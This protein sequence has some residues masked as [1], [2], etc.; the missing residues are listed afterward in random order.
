MNFHMVVTTISI[1]FS[2][3]ISHAQAINEIMASNDSSLFDFENDSPDW[4]ELYNDKSAAI[5]LTGYTLTDDP[6]K[7]YKWKFP[8][9]V[10]QPNEFLII[11]CSD[12]D[13]AAF[14]M[15]TGFKLDADG[16]F[17][18]LYNAAGVCVDSL[19]FPALKTDHSFG[20]LPDGDGE[21]LYMERPT[22]GNPNTSDESSLAAT[23]PT[24][25]H[26]SG[27]YDHAIHVELHSDLNGAE[28]H[29]TLDGAEPTKN[30]AVYF[31]AIAVDKTTVLRA[32][33][34]HQNMN[35]GP[36][37][38]RIFFI[39]EDATLFDMPIIALA[40]DP[41]NLWDQKTGIYAN[42]TQ[43]GDEWERPTN[44][45][46][47]EKGGAQ[48]FNVGAGVRIHGGASRKRADKKSFR[49]YFRSKYGPGILE[50]PIIP[51]TENDKFDRLIL[52]AGYNDSWA[53]W[54][55]D[56]RRA[57]TYHRDQVVRDLFLQLG[58]PA[59]HGEY[60][61]LFLNGDYW[62]LYNICE[63]YDDDFFDHYVGKDRWDVV[64]PGSDANQ[65]AVEA[66]DGD[67]DAWN[68]FENWFKQADFTTTRDYEEFK[69]RVDIDNFLD[70]YVIN[71]WA[72]NTDWPRHNWYAFRKRDDLAKWRFLPWDAE[73]AF[74][75]G[76]AA[77][78]ENVNMFRTILNQADK[79]PF[80]N[81]LARLPQNDEFARA[82]V[83]RYRSLS[84]GILSPGEFKNCMSKRTQQIQ[85]A[86]PFESD[87]WGGLFLPE[88]F[89]DESTW[90]NALEAMQRFA[91]HRDQYVR[92]HLESSL[93][94]G[95]EAAVETPLHFC[96]HAN[97]P[98]PFNPSTV[99]RFDLPHRAYVTLMIFNISGQ[100]IRTLLER[101]IQ[102]GGRSVEWN[103]VDDNG[104]KAASGVYIIRLQAEEFSA[105]Q[106]IAL[107]R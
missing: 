99:I 36:T 4:I 81:L 74:G 40:T 100:K 71:V 28:I 91:D 82:V 53:H 42:A 60:A 1:L 10:I 67:M 97:Y 14:R 45:I 96:L 84:Q 51:S 64:K 55:D 49:L 59:S 75:G 58:W 61:H 17:I 89:Y 23:A 26:A 25:S 34:F 8:K 103:G 22:P 33:V 29:F 30:S 106:R 7:T 52:R 5:D 105:S 21:F 68:E 31:G 86:I 41:E 92:R 13:T 79:H 88:Y 104:G 20:R 18:G 9:A 38:T 15:H 93:T 2:F 39:N 77:F 62:G 69:R 107:L 48:G 12:K 46:F 72:Q 87:R 54:S 24:I 44:I 80:A 27:P 90:E 85:S 98:N 66:A 70:F 16:E 102:R 6:A 63:R 57:A 95:V 11:F 78:M 35:P 50:Y 94:N 76:A 3:S 101:D 56:E 37:E 32:R 19:T 83:L 65:N 43:S 73:Y 47:M